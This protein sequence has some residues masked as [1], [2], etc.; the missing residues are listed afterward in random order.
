VDAAT[1]RLPENGQDRALAVPTAEGYLVAVADGAL[2]NCVRLP[3]GELQ[4]DVA[5]VV[6][7]G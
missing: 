7:A 6:V 4:D 2:V 1:R 3:S 5:V